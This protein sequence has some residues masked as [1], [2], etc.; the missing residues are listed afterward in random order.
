MMTTTQR[1]LNSVLFHIA[2]AIIARSSVRHDLDM[3]GVPEFCTE[4]FHIESVLMGVVGRATDEAAPL[5]VEWWSVINAA[6]CADLC[7]A[8]DPSKAEYFAGSPARHAIILKALAY[9][10]WQQCSDVAA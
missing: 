1:V 9:Y 2:Q 7:M 6:C 3:H 5:S 4:L 10:A 8:E